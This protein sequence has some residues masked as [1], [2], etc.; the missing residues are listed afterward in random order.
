MNSATIQIYPPNF[1]VQAKNAMNVQHSTSPSV[2]SLP[3]R[4]HLTS[5]ERLDIINRLK[6]NESGARIAR[7]YG[8]TKQ[9]VSAIKR[10]AQLMG[11]NFQ[12]KYIPGSGGGSS[13]SRSSSRNQS[14]TPLINSYSNKM[15]NYSAQQ[16]M[17]KGKYAVTMTPVLAAFDNSLVSRQ[18]KQQKVNARIA[19]FETKP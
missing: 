16:P 8:I 5:D 4:P 9:A 19:Y 2:A 12:N 3:K 6:R 17:T 18:L 10:R 11:D 7:D 13:N 15:L 14:P 1:T